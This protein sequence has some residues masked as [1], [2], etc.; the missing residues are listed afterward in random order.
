M[1]YRHPSSVTFL[2]SLCGIPGKVYLIIMCNCMPKKLYN[3]INI[4]NAAWILRMGWAAPRNRW[5][6]LFVYPTAVWV[7]DEGAV[8]GTGLYS[9]DIHEWC[10]TI[11]N[12]YPTW[13]ITR[14]MCGIQ[15]SIRSISFIKK[16]KKMKLM[17][18]W[19]NDE[20]KF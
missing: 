19:I 4:S 9:D 17:W 14:H 2:I 6:T 1:P 8:T 7:L 16:L 12:I 5:I 20:L 10:L 3:G 18:M 11:H 15:G 13:N